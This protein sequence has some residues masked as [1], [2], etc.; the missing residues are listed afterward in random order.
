MNH[1]AETMSPV[2][3]FVRQLA[4]GNTNQFNDQIDHYK[5]Q[6]K[7][8]DVMGSCRTSVFRV[9]SSWRNPPTEAQAGTS[10]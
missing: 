8:P 10:H 4:A 3:T 2:Y 7:A 5:K 9:A 6:A 1:P